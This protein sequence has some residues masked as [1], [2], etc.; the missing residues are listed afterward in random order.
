MSV[1]SYVAFGIPFEF[2]HW[3]LHRKIS[4][5]QGKSLLCGDTDIACTWGRCYCTHRRSVHKQGE[6]IRVLT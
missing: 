4:E 6:R 1:I 3:S 5:V 2:S